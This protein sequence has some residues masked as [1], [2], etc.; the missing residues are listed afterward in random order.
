MNLKFLNSPRLS[1]APYGAVYYPRAF[2]NYDLPSIFDAAST[3]PF[4]CCSLVS[5]ISRF[6]SKHVLQ[7]PC[8]LPPAVNDVR[9][10]NKSMVDQVLYGVGY[11]KL[12]PAWRLYIPDGFKYVLI[13]DIN[14]DQGKVALGILAFPPGSRSHCSSIPLPQSARDEEPLTAY[15]C[16]GPV[17]AKF[18]QDRSDPILDEIVPKIHHKIIVSQKVLWYFTAWASPSGA[19]CSMYVNFNPNWAPSPAPP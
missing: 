12:V 6:A 4:I 19:S 9:A 8:V 2:F 16:I 11:F 10:D 1:P 18:V 7:F 3:S 5:S 17:A 13:E 14:T 15:L